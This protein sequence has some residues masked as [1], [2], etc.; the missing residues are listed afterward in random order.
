MPKLRDPKRD[1]Q[2]L[3]A[4]YFDKN[5]TLCGYESKAAVAKKM[6]ISA[7]TLYKKLKDPES[8]TLGELLKLWQILHFSTEERQLYCS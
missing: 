1:R 3:F 5:M 4:A 7:A 2:R 8:F 6:G